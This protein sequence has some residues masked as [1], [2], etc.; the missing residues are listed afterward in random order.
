[1]K[2]QVGD[3]IMTKKPHACKGTEWQI[4]RTGADYR[5]RCTTCGRT[6]MLSY[7]EF[8]TKVKKI[9]KKAEDVQH[10]TP[11]QEQL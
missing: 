10:I 5:I 4:L 8:V 11:A 9:V 7:E 6:L 2:Y 3:I 1:M